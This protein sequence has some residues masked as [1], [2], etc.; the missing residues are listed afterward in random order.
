MTLG[1]QWAL[2]WIHACADAAA[3]NRE[4]LIDLDRAIGDADHGENVDRG[5]Q[6]V[7][8]KLDAQSPQT[9]SDVL[10]TTAQTLISTVGGASGPLLGTAFLRAAKAAGDGEIDSEGVVA[11]LQ[12]ALEGIQQRGKAKEGEKTMVDAWAPAAHAA[13][14]ASGSPAE[15]LA[16]AA[17]AAQ[18]GADATT[19]M[20]ATKGRASYLGERSL[21]HKDPGATS[22]A[23]FIE[24]AARTAQ[25]AQ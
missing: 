8:A 4:L 14:L 7:V 9:P 12:A 10:K 16:I 17:G 23:L 5:F 3:E 18:A 11:L 24:A 6:A 1:T 2:D 20:I 13:A 19:Q 22:S 21:G 15:V 25:E